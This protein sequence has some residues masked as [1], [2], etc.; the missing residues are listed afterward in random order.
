MGAPLPGE[1]KV[2]KFCVSLLVPVTVATSTAVGL[3]L[4]VDL[5]LALTA[6][7]GAIETLSAWLWIALGASIMAFVMQGERWLAPFAILGF[8]AGA[9]ELDAHMRFTSEDVSNLSYWF[10]ATIPLLEKLAV[11]AILLPIAVYLI[12]SLPSLANLSAPFARGDPAVYSIFALLF[13]LLFL[14]II[15]HLPHAILYLTDGLAIPVRLAAAL[16]AVEE[17]GELVLPA[18]GFLALWQHRLAHLRASS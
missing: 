11:L 2:H 3:L 4:P 12:A 18:L 8:F 7:G 9:R 1:T 10:N 13:F 14:R 5:I 15:D 6:E 16:R 17:I